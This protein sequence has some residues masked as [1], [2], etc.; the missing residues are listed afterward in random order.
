MSNPEG[1]DEEEEWIEIYNDANSITDIS[2]WQLDDIA[3]GSKSFT[4]PQNTLIAPKSYLIFSRQITKISLNNDIDSVRLLLPD[5]TVFQEINYEKPPQGKSSARTNEGF[6][7]SEPTP[8]MANIIGLSTNGDKQTIS[9]T[10]P[11]K[12]ETVKQSSKGSVISLTEDKIEGGYLVQPNEI[13][14][15]TGLTQNSTDKRPVSTGKLAGIKQSFQNP[16][17][18]T[19]LIITIVFASGFIGLLLVKF[20]KKSLPTQ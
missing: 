7:W 3:S 15:T 2:G 8:G 6:V 1:K 20:R 13:G 4:F 12:S 17:N 16:L 19:L 14:A 9:Q 11:I 10:N 5:G 18:L